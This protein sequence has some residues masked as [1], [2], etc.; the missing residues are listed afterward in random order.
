MSKVYERQLATSRHHTEVCTELD[1]AIA[2]F[3]GWPDD[4]FHALTI[5]QEE[6]GE[7]AKALL[8]FYYE[9]DKAVTVGDIR[10]EAI[11]SIAMLHRFLN[12][13]DKGQY[14]WPICSQHEYTA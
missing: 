11:Q 7:L 10:K 13:L 1:K 8:Q 5:V 14:R 6:V 9:Q 3:P 4:P 2:K 12:S